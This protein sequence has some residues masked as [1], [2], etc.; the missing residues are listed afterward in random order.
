MNWYVA[1]LKKYAVFEGR[2]SRTEF[3]MYAL[4]NFIVSVVLGIID[5]ML[6]LR[7]GPGIG[8][9]GAIYGLGV[10]LPGVGVSI[11]RMHDTGKSG[12]WLLIAFV[13]FIGWIIVIVLLA[14]D[15]EPGQNQYGPSVKGAAAPAAAF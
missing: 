6:G 4:F 3:W 13:P 8:L 14:L 10:L 11:R 5:G 9:L 12:W 1:V 2:A 15:S 7:F